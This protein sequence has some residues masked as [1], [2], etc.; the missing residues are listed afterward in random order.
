M[1][2][3]VDAAGSGATALGTVDRPGSW[4]GAPVAVGTTVVVPEIH[5]G[6]PGTGTLALLHLTV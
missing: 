6:G 3:L 1:L 2:S 5:G 4:F